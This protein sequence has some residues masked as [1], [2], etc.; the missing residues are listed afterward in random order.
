MRS[1]KVRFAFV[2]KINCCMTDVLGFIIALSIWNRQ[3]NNFHN[4]F[5]L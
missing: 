4:L 2:Q 3:T 1:L 5:P